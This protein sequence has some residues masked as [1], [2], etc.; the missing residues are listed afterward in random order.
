MKV[1]NLEAVVLNISKTSLGHSRNRQTTVVEVLIQ[2][3]VCSSRTGAFCLMSIFTVY[4][5]C[6][7]KRV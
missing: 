7:V 3:S 1:T 5:K 4:S 2:T 6:S